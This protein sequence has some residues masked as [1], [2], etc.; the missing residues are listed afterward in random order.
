SLMPLLNFRLARPEVLVDLNPVSELQYVSRTSSGGNGELRVGAMT[1]L[2]HL[3][4]S[5]DL[6]DRWQLVAEALPQVAHTPIRNRGTFGGGLAHA[7]P[8]AELCA[9]SLALDATLVARSQARGLREVPARDFY[10]GPYATALEPDEVLTEV[11]LPDQPEGAG[12]AFSEVARRRGDFALVGVAVLL[13]L[14]P[15]GMVGEARL[16]YASMGP[17]PLRA[18]GAERAL[19]RQPA[20]EA[21]FRA[22][23]EAALQELE[24]GDDLQAGRAYRLHVARVLTERA[25]GQ[26]LTRA[27]S[28]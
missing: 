22:A 21:S 6:G 7:D 3:E 24:P 5:P 2:R 28:S 17:R 10:R 11:R 18:Y 26:A 14:G 13:A 8:A 25:L 16:A 12:W 15:G 9:V 19:A 20:T 27:R 1:R 4:R 23:A